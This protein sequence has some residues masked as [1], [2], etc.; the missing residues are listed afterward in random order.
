MAKFMMRFFQTA[1]LSVLAFH[2][3]VP[4]FAQGVETRA[5][6][7][8][9]MDYE[10]GAI[11]FEKDADQ[12]MAPAS[13]SKL[14][15]IAVLFS[16]I[17][18]GSIR[19]DDEFSVSEKAWRMGGSK[20]FVMVDTK[21]RVEDLIRGIV[22]QSGN[23]ACIVIAEGISG[24]EAAFADEMTRFAREI[25]MENSTF[26]NSNG[27]PDPGHRM[28]AR[29]LG[30][31]AAHI[32]REYPDLYRF[33]SETEFTWADINQPN[34]NPL[35]YAEMGA[36]GLKTGYTEESGYGL[37]G[38]AVQDGRRLILVVNGLGSES[39]RSTESQRLLRV[40][41]RDFKFY[42]LYAASDVVGTAEVWQGD[43]P[44]INLTTKEP[45]AL[46]MRPKDRRAMKVSIN[47]EGPVKAPI[48]EGDQV[49]ELRVTLPGDTVALVQPLYAA[50]TVGP[51]GIFGK[52][53]MALK[54]FVMGQIS[55][56]SN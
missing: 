19:L 33:Y 6:Y 23:D 42:D 8:I 43:Q 5:K 51:M 31:L 4:V 9:M 12:L 37:V 47:Y 20:M 25:G 30:I 32:I 13:M 52:M 54:S 46:F 38:S 15:T 55:E 17:K 36:D 50:E 53:G 34:R 11:L 3:S 26:A 48:Q 41:F 22:I 18:E 21:I 7:A 40:G 16:K 56:E 28:T 14:M 49:A 39:E 45:V 44:L 29:E 10:T 2:I 35:L 1:L 24:S 27:M